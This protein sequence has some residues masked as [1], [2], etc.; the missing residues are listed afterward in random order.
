VVL[1][2]NPPA[3]LPDLSSVDSSQLQPGLGLTVEGSETQV[4]DSTKKA[5]WLAD[6]KPAAG[7]AMTLEGYYTVTAEDLYQFQLRGNAAGELLVDGQS[8][9]RAEDP[10]AGTDKWVMIPVQLA[11]GRH[12]FS[13]TGTV[14]TTPRLDIRFGNRGCQ[15]VGN[16]RFKH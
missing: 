8:L 13:L 6:Q 1:Q 2:V 5:S 4:I 16:D 7:K 3:L 12:H 9:W 15:T 10:Q 11:K 14:A